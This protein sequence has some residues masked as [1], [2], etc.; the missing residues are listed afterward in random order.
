[1]WGALSRQLSAPPTIAVTILSIGGVDAT[2]GNT[3]PRSTASAP[4]PVRSGTPSNGAFV[5]ADDGLSQMVQT[6]LAGSPP[7]ARFTLP[8]IATGTWNVSASSGSFFFSYSTAITAGVTL[9]TSVVMNTTTTFGFVSGQVLN[10]ANSAGIAGISIS[11]GAAVTNASG[12]FNVA[13][14]PGD[15]NRYGQPQRSQS[16]SIPRRPNW[17]PW[18]WGKCLRTIFFPL[19]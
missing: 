17:C 15:P 19:P 5:F 14:T 4:L 6:S 10:V 13:L 16:L 12:H 11:P 8:A 1:M 2:G 7:E 18:F 9:S 3:P